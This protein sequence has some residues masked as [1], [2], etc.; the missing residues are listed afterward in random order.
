MIA[1]LALLV[2]AGLDDE[3]A[4]VLAYRALAESG[5]VAAVEQLTEAIGDEQDPSARA[6]AQDALAR[7]ELDV[8]ALDHLLQEGNELARAWAA[9]QLGHY[10]GSVAAEALLAASDDPSDRVRREVYDSLGRSDDPRALNVLRKAAVADAS[11]TNRELAESAALASIEN[12][13]GVDVPLQMAR[14]K[15][16][17]PGVRIQAAKSLGEA[18]DWRAVDPLVHAAQTGEV[19]LRKTA[20]LALGHLGD[21]RAVEPIRELA[22][23]QSGQVRYAALAALAYLADE[24]AT[25]TLVALCADPDA[26][27]RQ[28]AVRAL[29]W[30]AAPGTAERLRPLLGDTSENVRAEVVLSLGELDEPERIEGLEQALDDVSPFVRSEAMRLL[31]ATGADVDDHCVRLLEDR[32]ALVRIAAAGACADR[33]VTGAVPALEKLASRTR[34]A[35]EKTYYEEALARLS[36]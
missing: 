9:H 19:E 3:Q 26:S 12:R 10:G 21:K 29:A 33:G 23:S 31:A 17:T 36:P 35:S 15:S 22:E 6:A 8:A 32:D 16:G 2:G 30:T 13:D 18:G 20:L 25:P 1:L 4:R 34:D 14:L 7:I 28:L 24:S 11:A 27:T 5:G